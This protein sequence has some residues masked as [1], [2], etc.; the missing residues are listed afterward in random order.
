MN[1]ALICINLNMCSAYTEDFD[2]RLT[3]DSE[4]KKAFIYSSKGD[5]NFKKVILHIL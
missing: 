3:N 1:T 5:M 4:F 2:G